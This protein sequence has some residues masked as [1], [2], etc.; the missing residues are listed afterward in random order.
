MKVRSAFS[1][2]ST[3]A[4][5]SRDASDVLVPWFSQLLRPRPESKAGLSPE[6]GKKCNAGCSPVLKQAITSVP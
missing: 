6:E 4:W 5:S 1:F 2:L 3:R